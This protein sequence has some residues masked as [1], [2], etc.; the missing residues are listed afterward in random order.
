[1]N[2]TTVPL[3]AATLCLADDALVRSCAVRLGNKVEVSLEAV[4]ET[5]GAEAAERLSNYW[6]AAT[7][8][9]S[10]GKGRAVLVRRPLVQVAQK[11]GKE[12]RVELAA[13]LAALE[14]IPEGDALVEALL[15]PAVQPDQL[16]S[17]ETNGNETSVTVTRRM[18][19]WPTALGGPAAPN[20]LHRHVK[21]VA[22]HA[23]WRD[24]K[25]RRLVRVEVS[26]DEVWPD[27][28][29]F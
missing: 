24:R 7:Q 1:M 4:K 27:P 14:L 12:G 8:M 6:R 22:N 13:E 10:S 15:G 29:C 3:T 18:V 16:T 21:I 23:K 25:V 11:D 28:A 5:A 17:V 9:W 19:E 26:C 2:E 20:E